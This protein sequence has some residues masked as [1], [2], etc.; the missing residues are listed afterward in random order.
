[1]HWKRNVAT[2]ARIGPWLTAEYTIL[3][4]TAWSARAPCLYLVAGNDGII[5]YAGISRNRLKDR[6]R[7]SP[8]YDA[9]TLERLPHNQLFHSQC[10]KHVQLEAMTGATFEV[11]CIDGKRLLTVLEQLGPPLSAFAALDGD[12]EGITAGVERWLCNNKSQQ[13]VSWNVAMTA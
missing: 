3:D 11:R 1:M 7:V 12:W 6:W 4:H 2:G 9:S 5:R 13:L 8:A 10:W